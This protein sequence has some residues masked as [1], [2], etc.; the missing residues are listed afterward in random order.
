M[1]KQYVSC[2]ALT[3][4]K[5]TMALFSS[6]F[7]YLKIKTLNNSSLSILFCIIFNAISSYRPKL[8]LE[9]SSVLDIEALHNT[10]IKKF[11]KRV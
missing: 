3:F 8:T 7:G 1:N 6:P 9:N 2:F 10:E 5:C 4:D 11:L